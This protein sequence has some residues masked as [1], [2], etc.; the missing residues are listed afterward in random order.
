MPAIVNN[1]RA[2]D[3]RWRFDVL[4]EAAGLDRARARAWTLGRV[5]QTCQW[6]VEDGEERLDE[7][8]L[9]VARLLLGR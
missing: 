2:Q 8:R 7:D 9:A 6:D 3:V 4:T 5:R 1:F